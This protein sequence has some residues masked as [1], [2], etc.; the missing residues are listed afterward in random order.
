MFNSSLGIEM[1]MSVHLDSVLFWRGRLASSQQGP[2]PAHGL[3]PHS[4]EPLDPR[5]GLCSFDNP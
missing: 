4:C 3:S 2:V 5:T 1:I